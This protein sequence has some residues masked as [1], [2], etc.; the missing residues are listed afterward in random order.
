MKLAPLL[1]KEILTQEVRENFQRL[2]DF[3]SKEPI[4]NGQWRLI[5]LTFDSDQANFKYAHGLK[6]TPTDIIQTRQTGTGTLAFNYT[7]FD[8]TNID[9]TA[10][11]TSASDPLKVRFLVG[12][13]S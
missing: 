12:R 10:A 9:L 7:R 2:Q 11:G 5:E 8:A 3:L 1:I 6:F 4:I 13:L